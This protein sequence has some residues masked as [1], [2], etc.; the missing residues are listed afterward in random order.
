F[1]FAPFYLRLG[2]ALLRGGNRR[3]S[4][5]GE[6]YVI[7]SVTF[8]TLTIP[9][10]LEGVWT[11]A[12]WAVEAA[13]MYWLGARQHRLYARAFALVVLGLAVGRLV[14]EL[15]ID[16]RPGTPLI[17]GSVLSMALLAL[18]TLAM[19]EVR[20]RVADGDRSVIED[21]NAVLL[22]LIAVAAI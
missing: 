20:R 1:G 11:G 12:T 8:G 13:G 19:N 6:A 16:L 4:L 18:S 7:V 15:G 17:T 14:T 21:A 2:G 5:L 10:A 3:Y 22:P 9:L